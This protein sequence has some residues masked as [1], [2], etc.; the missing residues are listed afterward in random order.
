MYIYFKLF[1]NGEL[2]L[3]SEN[4]LQAIQMTVC[5]DTYKN[6]MINFHSSSGLKKMINSVASPIK[7]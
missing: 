6:L 4:Q 5:I 1:A 2:K 7:D 3:L